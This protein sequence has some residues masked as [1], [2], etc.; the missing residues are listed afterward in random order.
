MRS[1]AFNN[2]VEYSAPGNQVLL[3]APID[4]GV[5]RYQH[6]VLAGASVKTLAGNTS[7][8]GSLTRAGTATVTIPKGMTLTYGPDAAVIYAGTA[9]QTTG[10]ELP[11]TSAV[12]PYLRVANP[13]GVKLAKNVEVTDGLMLGGDLDTGTA[14]LTLGAQ[15]GCAGT[16]D[17]TGTVLRAA[18]P[19]AGTYCFGNPNVQITLLPEAT[20]PI[21][22]S[23]K[24]TRGAA[25]FTGAVL[26]RYQITAPGFLGAAVLRLPY[27]PADLNGNDPGKLQ[28]WRLGGSGWVLQG[29]SAHGVDPDGK[30]YVEKNG[31]T[32]FSDWTLATAGT[33]TAV[34]VAAF[35]A[36][37]VNGQRWLY[38]QT[39][40]ELD[41]L[42]FA[43]Y[44]SISPATRGE[45]IGEIAAQGTGGAAGAD[46]RWQDT[47]GQDGAVGPPVLYYWLD[48]ID[49]AA[50]IVPQPQGA[51]LRLPRV[52]LPNLQK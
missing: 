1:V 51:A 30:P 27:N 19:A 6:L 24:L 7:V 31:V 16:G 47:E 52:Y 40:S 39:A 25:P 46:Y 2:V 35:S 26:L 42:G 44:R 34:T 36:H 48:V 43:I 50:G 17:V 13:G 4:N 12:A 29:A 10:P 5:L 9:L 49:Q 15:A 32:A 33:P 45:R 41:C 14:T 20:P 18:P 3:R 8:E 22:I 37:L 38:W 11:G 28:L 23:V 21:S